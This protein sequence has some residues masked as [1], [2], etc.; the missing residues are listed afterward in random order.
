MYLNKEEI[1]MAAQKVILE[2]LNNSNE[3]A[4]ATVSFVAGA[5]AVTEELIK[6]EGK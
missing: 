6:E 1:L 5:I 2:K 3:L 4:V